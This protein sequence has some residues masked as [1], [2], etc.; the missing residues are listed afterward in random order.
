MH[1]YMVPMESGVQESELAPLHET[2]PD[3]LFGKALRNFY[4]GVCLMILLVLLE[5]LALRT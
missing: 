2:S 4:V 1:N 3:I 5:Y